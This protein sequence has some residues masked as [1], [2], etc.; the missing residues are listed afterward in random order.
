MVLFVDAAHFVFGAF[1]GYLW[2]FARIFIKTPSGRQRLNVLGAVNSVTRK[3]T[4][5]YNETYINAQTVCDFLNV[6]AKEYKDFP[7]T[8]IM[9]N[10]RYQR[11][12]LVMSLALELNIELLFIPPYSPNLNLIERYWKFLKKKCLNA[13]YYEKFECFK[14][15]ILMGIENSNTIWKEQIITLI[16]TE[17]QSFKIQKS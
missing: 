4:T 7:I 2:C 14:A 6:I 12:K 10:A 3:I 16:S 17:F 5:I 1:M 9:D 11:C 13:K 15:A 8:L